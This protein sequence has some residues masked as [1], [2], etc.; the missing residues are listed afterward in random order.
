[1]T[2]GPTT[3]H[4]F[5][6]LRA[7]E[8][9]WSKVDKNGPTMPHMDSQCWVW[10]GAARV[11]ACGRYGQFWLNGRT[12]PAARV[13]LLS[14]GVDVP[15]GYFACHRCD[16]PG[17]V[18]PDHLFPGTPMD[19][20]RDMVEKGR[21]RGPSDPAANVRRHFGDD[22]WTRRRPWDVPRGDASPAARRPECYRGERN[23]RAKLTADAV[24]DMRAAAELGRRTRELAEQYGVSMSTVQ[25]VLNGS[26]WPPESTDAR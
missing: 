15:P 13:A 21:W 18:R 2:V 22:H 19:N 12:V 10:T 1:M 24:R 9:F 6:D 7:L 4:P 8:R 26:A 3:I 5:P 17:C 20:A 11:S 25:R 14:A 23:G 16:N